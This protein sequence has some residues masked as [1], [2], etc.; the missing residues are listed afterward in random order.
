ML[1]RVSIEEEDGEAVPTGTFGG[2]RG[3]YFL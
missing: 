1:G 2:R 3:V